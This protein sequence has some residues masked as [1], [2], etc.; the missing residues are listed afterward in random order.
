MT[1]TRLI[2]NCPKILYFIGILLLQTSCFS[3]Y[4]T[5]YSAA[6]IK[7]LGGIDKVEIRKEDGTVVKVV[8]KGKIEDRLFLKKDTLLFIEIFSIKQRGYIVSDYEIRMNGLSPDGFIELKKPVD[9]ALDDSNTLSGQVTYFD[10][11]RIDLS[12]G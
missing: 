4:V 5:I 11:E 10:S 8:F 6:G 2:N 7:V 12:E 1:V 3:Q 9:I